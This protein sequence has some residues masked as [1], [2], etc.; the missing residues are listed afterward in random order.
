MREEILCI[1]ILSMATMTLQDPHYRINLPSPAIPLDSLF[2]T[3]ATN[4]LKDSDE[5]RKRDGATCESSYCNGKI[6]K[7]RRDLCTPS[8]FDRTCKVILINIFNSIFLHKL[9]QF[10]IP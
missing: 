5:E 1:G 2:V 6:R 7:G 9:P 8:L 3:V 4:V 10:E